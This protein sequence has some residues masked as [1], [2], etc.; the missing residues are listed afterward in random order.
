MS[1]ET[2]IF[3][4]P[5]WTEVV[6]NDTVVAFESQFLASLYADLGRY[7]DLGNSDRADEVLE[8]INSERYRL[9]YPTKSDTQDRQQPYFP[10]YDDDDGGI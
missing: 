5:D 9:K 3:P 10:E 6:S 2:K 1:Q 4:S 8:E 7:A